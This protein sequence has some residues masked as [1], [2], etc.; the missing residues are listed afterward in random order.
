MK[1]IKQLIIKNWSVIAIVIIWFGIV[2]TNFSP[3]TFLSGWDNL[4]SEFNFS[5]NLK[6]ALFASW[7]EYQGLGLLG[8]M[9]HGADLFRQI[10]LWISSL[11]LPVNFI[12]Y[13]FHFSML[14]S[15]S[16]GIYFLLKDFVLEKYS[17]FG[18]KWG[19]L[20]G[21]IFYLFNLG[22]LQSFYLAWE[23]FSVHFGFLPWL[24]WG[25]FKYLREPS[26]KNLLIFVLINILAV[27][28]GYVATVFL[29][30]VMALG[31]VLAGYVALGHS[32][33]ERSDDSRIR[34]WMRPVT[35]GLTRMTREVL[36]IF[37]IIFCVNAFW[38]VPNLYFV[39]ND[40]GTNTGAKMNLMATEDNLLRNKEYGDFKNS[41]LLKGFWF[42]NVELQ[43]NGS[44]DYIMGDWVNH[45][46]N[47]Y[48]SGIGYML[49]GLSVLG[50]IFS[51]TTK[52][53]KAL[54]F[55]PVLL[56]AFTFLAND[57]IGFF[58][59]NK[60]LYK[61]PLFSQ[62]FRFPFTKFSI[63]TAFC[64]AVFYGVFI[65]VILSC[66]RHSGEERS[67]DSRIRF[68]MR[69]SPVGG[70]LTRMTIILFFILLPI[71]FLYPIFQ[72]KLFYVKE[73][74]K[75]PAEYFLVFD[76]FKNQDKNTRIAN[77]PQPTFWGWTNYNWGNQLYSG[78]GFLWYGIKQP[79]LDR[80]FDVWSKQ[81]ENY[82]WEISYA[83]YSKNRELFEN[84]L[85]KYQVNWLLVDGNVI[86]PGAE[87]ALFLEELEKL[88]MADSSQLTANS[89]KQSAISYKQKL[90]LVQTF[91]K[92]KIYKINLETGVNDFV[93]LGEN[94]PV[95][96][97]YEWGNYD[98]AYGEIGNYI[99]IDR[100]S[101]ED[102]PFGG[103]DSRIDVGQA[104][105]TEEVYYPF[106]SVFTGR[107]TDELDIEIE[108]LGDRIVFKAPLPDG[109][110]NYLIELPKDYDGKELVEVDPGSFETKY[111]LPTIDSDGQTLSVVFPK[112]K[113]LLS[114]EINPSKQNLQAIN[115]NQ[116]SQGQVGLEN[117]QGLVRLQAQDATNCGAS[118][119]LPDLSHK[120]AYL[121]S[122]EAKNI[123]GKP[124]LFWLENLTNRKA[125][126]EVY[127]ENSK[128]QAPNS[129]QSQNTKY[130]I[131]NTFVQP[132]MADDGL[133]YTL[134]FDNISI[135][136]Q[137]SINELG[138]I[139]VLPIPYNFLTSLKLTQISNLKSQNQNAKLKANSLL[140]SHPNPSLY[141][142][143]IN[144]EIRSNEI[145]I[146]SQSYHS[147]WLAFNLDTKRIIK[148][149]FVVNN[150][151]NGWIL[152]A[153]TQ[154]LLPNTYILFFWP[155]YLQYLGFGFYLIILLFWLRAKS[156]K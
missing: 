58:S 142:V 67:D 33:E 143:Q 6:R 80:A 74:A 132:P 35:A 136:R 128:F 106:R 137:E 68:W 111:F 89:N 153:N 66:F 50:I 82:Y 107:K 146:L 105:M 90:E 22:T 45:F 85:E 16:L 155:Q 135:G 101:G 150:W 91:G 69:S 53:K 2:L 100:H 134:H 145:L 26:K 36:I 122:A 60:I 14:L 86:N 98:R 140:I 34:F 119:Y 116:F 10:L 64:L 47:P 102:P 95:I 57:T 88:L 23:A 15:G 18:K 62:I 108:D 92:I 20:A 41:A 127:L 38:L 148:D 30:Y 4:H 25:V 71:I 139:S 70:S 12:R 125:D 51:L 112:I 152:L 73:K 29:V 144:G 9:G 43:N 83:L 147:G 37:L 44:T 123:S 110:E 32:G 154:P 118:F 55:L 63:L 3:N 5:I 39:F 21:A 114:A 113:G 52:N 24:F 96:N 1:K 141:K 129:K 46:Q 94:L 61:L 87:K 103:D 151:S 120:Y 7:Q 138:K 79:I 49:F 42:E 27:S 104:S 78:S 81:N 156:R 77:F 17:E 31:L 48:F 11:V 65:S 126:Q 84:I 93:W 54:V 40:V 56:L 149:H 133:G 13:F 28:Q 59:L 19:A 131:Q 109:F 117:M 75:I 8:G 99:S 124:L 115:C 130:K 97:S 72:G 121:I 76:F